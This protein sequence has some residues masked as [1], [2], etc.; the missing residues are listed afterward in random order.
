MTKNE[1][2]IK[3]CINVHN[4]RYDYSNTN[5]INNNTKVEII[6]KK[7]GA[8]LQKPLIHIDNC[9]CPKCGLDSM[10]D[11]KMDKNEKWLSDF[12][13]T[14]GDTYDY[15][16]SIYINAK[17]K[18]EIICKEHGSFFQR[19]SDHKR[20][21]GCAICGKLKTNLKLISNNWLLDF[22]N[23][24]G[25]LYDYSKSIYIKDK[26]KIEI[27]CKKHGSFFQTPALHKRGSGCPNCKI[28]KGENKIMDYL[29]INNIDFKTQF[30]FED[31]RYVNRLLFDFYIPS[32][33]ICIEYDGIQHFESIDHFGGD[34][35]L[36]D[37]KIKDLIKNKW[38]EDN[39]INLLRISYKDYKK[40]DDIISKLF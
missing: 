21:Y 26:I 35:R 40:I 7:H 24:H 20:G 31:C 3:K 17:S 10:I 9:G 36:E 4:D 6:C 11:S 22:K 29:S 1:I 18:I 8:F 14:H 27:I 38:C 33:N 2:F 12:K 32:K 16:K 19:V 30:S 39:K 23:K 15:S 13:N 37:Q 28:S 34:K 5:Y 25:N